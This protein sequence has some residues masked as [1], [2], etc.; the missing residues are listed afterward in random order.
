[1]NT[2]KLFSMTAALAALLLGAAALWAAPPS[3]A[4]LSG[5]LPELDR[6]TNFQTDFTAEYTE[7]TA[8]PGQPQSVV[9][10]TV[11]R[12]DRDGSMTIIMLAPQSKKGQGYVQVSNNFWF[13]DPSSRLFSHASLKESWQNTEAMNSDFFRT[14]W[15]TDYA[16][17]S[18]GEGTLG[19]YPVYVL[20]LK[21]TNDQVTFP[22]K[23]IWVRKDISIVL[24]AED[25]SLSRRLMRTVYYPEYTKIGEQY[26]ATRML[27]VDEL[28]AG[29]KTQMTLADLSAAALPDFTFTKAFLQQVNR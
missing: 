8:H 5:L 15:A 21:G 1:M 28:N 25:Y 22:F 17:E 6:L 10:H 20:E 12:R 11:Y 13:Y 18:Q 2:R 4:D 24:K 27:M 26:V 3:Q 23:K 16:I 19:V 9:S 7:V 29:D 14:S